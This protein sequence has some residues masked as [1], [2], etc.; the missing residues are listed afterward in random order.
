MPVTRVR[1]LGPSPIKVAPL[2]GAPSL[3]FSI[4]YASVQLNTNLPL[5]ISTCP[6][7]KL[8]AINAGF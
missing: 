2:I 3:P 7:P 6:P 8:L 5:V 4:L 1:T